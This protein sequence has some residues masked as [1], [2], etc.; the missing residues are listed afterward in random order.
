MLPCADLGFAGD[1]SYSDGYL[2]QWEDY[3]DMME[4]LISMV[5]FLAGEGNHESGPCIFLIFLFAFANA[6]LL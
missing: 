6:M 2:G 4:P 1:L 3:L 5:P